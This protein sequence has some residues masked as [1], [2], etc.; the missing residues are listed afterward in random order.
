MA[1]IFSRL[2]RNFAKNGYFPTDEK[3]MSGIVAR[4]SFFDV[5]GNKDKPGIVRMLDPCCGEGTALAECKNHL[6]NSYSGGIGHT[7]EAV[8]V[9]I[10]KERAYHA[11]SM[12]ILD[13]V[14]HG[15]LNNCY[16]QA[17][18]F[19]LLFLNPP[20]GKMLSD[21]LNVSDQK[22][23]DTYE[24]M[25]YENTNKLLQFGGVMILVIPHYS[26]NNKLATMIA[27]HFSDVSLF[28]SP[29]QRFKQTVL[30]G[31]R[32]KATTPN[33]STIDLLVKAAADITTLP[34]LTDDVSQNTPY[35][36]AQYTVP[37]SVGE[38]KIKQIELDT[39]QLSEQ[40]SGKKKLWSNF[41]TYFSSINA[42]VY[43]PLNRLSD[44]HVGLS[45][46]AGK[47]AGKVTS[48]NGRCLLVKGNTF[49]DKRSTVERQVKESGEVV[50]IQTHTDIFVPTIKAIDLTKNSATFGE[51]ITIK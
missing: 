21:K 7:I 24:M 20:Y 23:A 8:G 16:M 2:A 46:A 4:L 38:F 43:Y 33:K 40:L 14:V 17:R 45:L 27:S 29:E 11:K 51:V 26:F 6:E 9:E 19:G 50:E 30:F 47:I 5:E 13:T 22:G 35:Q 31:V 10:D 1:L 28:A 49:K 36:T 34:V 37:L 15:N 48:D 32:Q 42:T 44:W 3:T 18:Q 12:D 41:S 39:E 25:F